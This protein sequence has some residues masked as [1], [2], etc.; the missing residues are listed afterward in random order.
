M[1]HLVEGNLLNVKVAVK[2]EISVVKNNKGQK[3]DECYTHPIDKGQPKPITFV[4][5]VPQSLM[6]RHCAAS[7][8][9]C[10]D[11]S[12]RWLPFNYQNFI[13]YSMR[14]CPNNG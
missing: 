6:P 1:A 7:L 12:F 11:E 4:A 10:F 9:H 3:K 5:L 13:Y 14:I 2:K 8:I